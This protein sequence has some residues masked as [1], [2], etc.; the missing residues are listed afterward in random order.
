MYNY[1]IEKKMK[2]ER[3]LKEKAQILSEVKKEKRKSK[4]NNIKIKKIRKN[5]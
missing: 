3:E 2:K 1:N 4:K 5:G